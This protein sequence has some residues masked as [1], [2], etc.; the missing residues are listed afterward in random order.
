VI[1]TDFLS[2]DSKWLCNNRYLQ[3]NIVSSAILW[4]I[5]SNRNTI[6]FNIKAWLN[7]KHV[8]HLILGYLRDWKIPFKDQ[9]WAL[10]DQFKKPAS[11]KSQD[12][13]GAGAGLSFHSFGS[14][15][16]WKP[17]ASFSSHGG[18]ASLAYLQE[19]PEDDVVHVVMG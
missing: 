11:K 4:G 19:H 18:R 8:W 1:I 14:I 5:W 7:V 16:Y 6:V 3:L 12:P 17:S 9:D 13:T 15:S 10:V 2:I